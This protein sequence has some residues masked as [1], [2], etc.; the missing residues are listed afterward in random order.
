MYAPAR[1]VATTVYR[2][3]YTGRMTRA[4]REA[5]QERL[6]RREE[7]LDEWAFELDNRE[8]ELFGRRY[9]RAYRPQRYDTR[10]LLSERELCNWSEELDAEAQYLA[11]RE[12]RLLD[13]ANDRRGNRNRR[14]KRDNG[15]GNG[16]NGNGN[17]NGDGNSNS[18]GMCP[19]GW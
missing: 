11:D 9:E 16:N 13:A 3:V 17:G 10:F 2:Q 6:L 14:D 19:P 1:T 8:A 15:W 4:E 5:L 18:G 12:Q 7:R